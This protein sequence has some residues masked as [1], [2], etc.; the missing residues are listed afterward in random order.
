MDGWLEVGRWERDGQMFGG[1]G[2]GREDG[3]GE[4]GGWSDSWKWD[5]MKGRMEGDILNFL[6]QMR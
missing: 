1:R 3:V 6:S 4:N 2:E 5:G